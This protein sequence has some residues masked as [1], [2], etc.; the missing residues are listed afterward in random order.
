MDR[1]SSLQRSTNRANSQSA[2]TVL[3]TIPV[4]IKEGIGDINIAIS[5]TQA[6]N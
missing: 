1:I 5:I 2:S 3:A 6:K 4:S